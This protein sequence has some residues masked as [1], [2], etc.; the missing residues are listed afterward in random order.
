MQQ[1]D[2]NSVQPQRLSFKKRLLS[3]A[4]QA[5]LMRAG[6]SFWANTL[7]VL[8][9]HRIGDVTE[10]SFDTFKPNVS[11]SPSEFTKQMDYVKRWFNAISIQDLVQ[12][13]D[14]GKK[15][16][17]HAAL[18]T[19]DDG[20]LDNFVSAYPILRER[21]LPAIIFLAT[22][23][24]QQDTPFF[25]DLVAYCFHHT[26]RDG[27]TLP[28]GT[29]QHWGNNT[30]MET[31]S[32]NLIED[33]KKMK[34]D[35]KKEWVSH[36]PEILNVSIPSGY[37][38][39]LMMNWDQIRQMNSNGID[40]GGHTINHPILTRIPL[41]QAKEEIS[42]SGS[43]IAQETGKPVYSFAYPNGGRDDYSHEIETLTRDSGYRAAFTLLNGPESHRSIKGNPFAIRRI[44]ISHKHT[45]P[46]FALLTNIINR[47]RE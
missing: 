32:K 12:W 11:A 16:P 38:Q 17:P 45:M 2:P 23:H 27:I 33:L 21:N 10:K 37:F 15:L 25:W 3:F 40:F 24:I 20:Y 35:D 13:L 8:N 6:R 4:F 39:S 29:Q 42:G 18:I 36:L 14:G 9:Y 26:H 19:F 30:E 44:F 41:Q 1:V 22:G 47:Y 5:G 28:N 7:T 34:D 31:V 46:D 43:R